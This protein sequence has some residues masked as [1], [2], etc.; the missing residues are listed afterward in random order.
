MAILYN[1]IYC[2]IDYVLNKDYMYY[3]KINLL[4]IYTT[5]SNIYILMM[6]SY[7]ISLSEKGNPILFNIS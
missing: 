4:S 6:L 3:I 7:T 1:I 2:Y 5:C